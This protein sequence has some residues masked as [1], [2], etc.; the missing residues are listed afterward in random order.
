MLTIGKKRKMRSACSACD[1]KADVLFECKYAT[2]TR[3]WWL[4]SRCFGIIIRVKEHNTKLKLKEPRSVITLKQAEKEAI[5]A[6]QLHNMTIT[7]S[8]TT[9]GITR[10]TMYAKLKEHGL[11][12]N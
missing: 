11:E 1:S 6:V 7:D 10:A 2:G 3:S 4:C 8:A 12:Q 5:E 9:L